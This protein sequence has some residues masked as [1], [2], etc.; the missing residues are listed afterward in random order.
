[1]RKVTL[2][3]IERAEE[4]L[5]A[6]RHLDV[7]ETPNVAGVQA[8]QAVEK[9]LK[10]TWL[11]LGSPVPMTHD[12]EE[13]WVGVETQ[14]QC[15]INL[16]SLI[17]LSPFGTSVRY[18]AKRITPTQAAWAVEFALETCSKLKIWLVNANK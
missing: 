4:D 5:A 7:N 3:W 2:E 11:E 9:F 8:Q 17:M 15:E 14:V 13:L 18:P 16:R 10:A 6:L 12:L 1:M